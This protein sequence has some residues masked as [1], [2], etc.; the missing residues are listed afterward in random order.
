MTTLS[1]I[2]LNPDIEVGLTYEAI[3]YLQGVYEDHTL[4]K[5]L[6]QKLTR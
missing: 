3:Y 2:I 6:A 5:A 4:A 1:R